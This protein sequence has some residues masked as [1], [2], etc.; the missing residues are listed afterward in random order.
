MI[1]HCTFSD[2]FLRL[3][4]KDIVPKIINMDPQDFEIFEN[5]REIYLLH[6][7]SKMIDCYL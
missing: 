6:S 2:F 5:M 3:S 7:P 4:M 1:L